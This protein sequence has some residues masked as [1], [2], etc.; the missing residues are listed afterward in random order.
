MEGKKS[1][2]L[3]AIIVM[4]CTAGS[5]LLGF[6]RIAV[7]SAIFGG[8]AQAD[9]ANSVFA[10]PN[11]LRKLMAEGA[12][13]AAFVPVFSKIHDEKD[14]AKD[15]GQSIVGLQ[16]VLLVPVILAG[17]IFADHVCNFLFDFDAEKMGLAVDLFR[18]MFSYLLLISISAI[19]M[20]M[21]NAS[22]QFVVPAVTPFLFSVSV[23]SS[24]I[25]F[26][27]SLGIYSFAIGVLVGGIAQVVFQIPA[28]RKRGLS[29]IP[30]FHFKTPEFQQVM[31]LWL[32]V[33]GI[34][35][36]QIALQQFA[37]Y[38]ASGLEEG[39]VTALNNSLVFFQLPLGVFSASLST[40][41]FTAMSRAAAKDDH[42][43][44]RISLRKGLQGLFAFLIPSS[45][46]LMIMSH[47]VVTVAIVR[48][49]YTMEN[50]YKAV[51]ALMTY[52]PGLFAV[53][54]FGFLQRYFY[55]TNNRKAPL[56]A[57]LIVGVVDVVLT[58][59][60]KD[61]LGV[62][63]IGLANTISFFCGAMYLYFM[64]SI[65]V[66]G[67]RIKGIAVY[68]F[69]VVFALIPG[70]LFAYFFPIIIGEYYLQGS[71]MNSFLL[72]LPHGCISLA[73][74]FVA[75][76]VFRVDFIREVMKR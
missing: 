64:I 54:S 1:T 37:I 73:L 60:L 28:L 8:G 34:A 14:K 43:G 51:E 7:V 71:T 67:F 27:N 70:S 15:L 22:F 16:F 56:I 29:L 32:P 25:F 4:I 35:G 18:W 33:I 63:A 59:L 49:S 38:I 58:L 6:I 3:Q 61:S 53:G 48:G 21:L 44:V 76:L 17:I 23:I 55:A 10:I 36:I 46:L 24:I 45:V 12:L 66:G 2:N 11:N 19:A 52:A 69:K 72:L 13:S 41:Y 31:R 65:K 74:I 57:V 26:H 9:A 30:K 62:S 5:R 39:S 20:G 42:Q 75:F 50:M 68:F 40:V 47:E